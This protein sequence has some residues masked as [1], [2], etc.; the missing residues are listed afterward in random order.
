MYRKI[1]NK[2]LYWFFL[3]ANVANQLTCLSIFANRTCVVSGSLLDVLLVVQI[4]ADVFCW[5]Q[6]A[7][8]REPHLRVRI[9]ANTGTLPFPSQNGFTTNDVSRRQLY[10]ATEPLGAERGC[11]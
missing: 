6:Y 3:D 2:R 10:T 9:G 8:N 5:M 1:Y 7:K 4:A 11:A